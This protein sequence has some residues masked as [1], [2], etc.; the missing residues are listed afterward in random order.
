[1]HRGIKESEVIGRFRKP[2][3]YF[4]S[5]QFQ[6]VLAS[7]NILGRT[8]VDKEGNNPEKLFLASEVEAIYRRI[9]KTGNEEISHNDAFI[10]MLWEKYG[11]VIPNDLIT[12]SLDGHKHAEWYQDTLKMRL[13][14]L[15]AQLGDNVNIFT[16][17][18]LGLG[19]GVNRLGVT[20]AQLVPMEALVEQSEEGGLTRVT[21]WDLVADPK[22]LSTVKVWMSRIKKGLIE[23][24]SPLKLQSDPTEFGTEYYLSTKTIA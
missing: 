22:R 6:D 4:P 8:P 2:G 7:H 16:A 3:V 21:A 5:W 19:V 14:R 20:R 18:K 11:Y 13:F 12:Y 17:R 1:M 9:A 10:I 23:S 15:R 24:D